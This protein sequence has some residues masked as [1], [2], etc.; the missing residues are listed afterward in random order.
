MFNLP[1][2]KKTVLADI[3]LFYSAAIWG[4]TFFLVKMII[5]DIDPVVLVSYRFLLAGVILLIFLLLK[6]KPVFQNIGIGLFLGTIIWL[7]YI[8]QTIG[9]AYTTAS[10]SGFITGLFVA[11][12]PLFLQFVLK[13]KPTIMEIS[14]SVISLLGLWI[15]TGGLSDMNI[16]DILTVA[17]AMAYAMH[18]LYA[19]KYMKMGFDPIV[20]ACQQFLTVG[21]LSLI[22]AFIFGLSF[23][24]GTAQ[25][26]R[27]VVFLAIFP[28]L[29]AFLIQMIAQKIRGPFR[30]SLI[31][32]LEP[33]FAGLF[34]WTLGG[35]EFII[36]RAL[37][38]LVIFS[39][40]II[41]GIPTPRFLWRYGRGKK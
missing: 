1:K 17:A 14:A 4:S 6:R 25:T 34:A 20:F 2:T 24:T 30:V 19:D 22:T 41:S 33:V 10:N 27:I 12:I 8:P 38:G 29:S 16:G 23:S 35:E 13:R 40:L 18:V 26:V 11:F 5:K 15:L 7:L 39:A 31:F 36:R 3:G 9:L 37:G 21:L 28:T 32:A